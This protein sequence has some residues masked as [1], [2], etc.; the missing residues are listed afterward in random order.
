M[1]RLHQFFKNNVL[2]DFY[3][4]IIHPSVDYAVSVWGYYSNAHQYLV[5]RL[6]HRAARIVTGNRDYVNVRGEGLVRELGWQTV[7]QITLPCLRPR[8]CTGALLRSPQSTR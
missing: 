8:S 4:S 6:Q 5:K 2:N 7:D 1:N 3:T